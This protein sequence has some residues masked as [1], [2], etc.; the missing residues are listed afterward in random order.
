MQLSTTPMFASALLGHG[1]RHSQTTRDLHVIRDGDR[2]EVGLAR[3]VKHGPDVPPQVI[4]VNYLRW[5]VIYPGAGDDWGEQGREPPH[6]RIVDMHPGAASRGS[7]DPGELLNED[8]VPAYVSVTA[9]SRDE[10]ANHRHRR[11]LRQDFADSAA[12]RGNTLHQYTALPIPPLPPVTMATFALECHRAP[13]RA[14]LF[15]RY[16]VDRRF[17]H[18]DRMMGTG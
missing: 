2:W 16:E 18:P 6:V 4:P 14:D 10:P 5:D 9:L 11:Q 17:P 13:F 1:R 7:G 8:V 3:A 15:P 12:Q